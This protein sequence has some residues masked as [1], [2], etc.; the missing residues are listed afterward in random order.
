MIGNVTRLIHNLAICVTIHVG[1]FDG[2]QGLRDC[3]YRCSTGTNWHKSNHLARKHARKEP[4]PIRCPKPMYRSSVRCAHVKRPTR[5][6]LPALQPTNA[7]FAPGRGTL[8]D[9]LGKPLQKTHRSNRDDVCHK[10]GDLHTN[11]SRHSSGCCLGCLL[12]ANMRRSWPRCIY[13]LPD[14]LQGTGVILPCLALMRKY[15]P[16]LVRVLYSTK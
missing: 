6:Q 15:M 2:G 5:V 16:P 9:K 12:D 4:S 10:C 1:Q 8:L 14:T 7:R 3:L 11:F 13:V